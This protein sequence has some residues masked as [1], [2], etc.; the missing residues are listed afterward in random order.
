VSEKI[1]CDPRNKKLASFFHSIYN[2]G[3]EET[4]LKWWIHALRHM[5]KEINATVHNCAVQLYLKWNWPVFKWNAIAV[6]IVCQ[7]CWFKRYQIN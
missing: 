3:L 1:C 6:G 2:P 7:S 4:I 5:W